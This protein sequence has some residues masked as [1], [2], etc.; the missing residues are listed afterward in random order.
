MLHFD[1]TLA[2][3]PL[4]PC[5]VTALHRN[6]S[7]DRE[8]LVSRGGVAQAKKCMVLATQLLCVDLAHCPSQRCSTAEKDCYIPERAGHCPLCNK[9]T[10]R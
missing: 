9:C 6:G 3:S 7:S 4:L 8:S 2:T 1:S 5:L 10:L